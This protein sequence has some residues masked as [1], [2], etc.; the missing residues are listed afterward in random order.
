M[1]RGRPERG[2]AWRCSGSPPPCVHPRISGRARVHV[3]D[4]VGP[5][6]SCADAYPAHLVVSRRA[7]IREL[8]P[9]N[10]AHQAQRSPRRNPLAAIAI[11]SKEKA[12]Q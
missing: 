6:D 12:T 2:G 8:V 10:S 9:D 3:H 11:A 7:D 4:G 1:R 5:L